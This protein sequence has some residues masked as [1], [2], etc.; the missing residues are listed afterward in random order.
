[1]QG[2]GAL[3]LRGRAAD[4]EP[5][6]GP[7]DQRQ[8]DHLQA[9][10]AG[11]G[12]RVLRRWNTPR[13]F[14]TAI[15]LYSSALLNTP[16]ARSFVIDFSTFSTRVHVHTLPTCVP[17]HR[18][19]LVVYARVG[20]PTWVKAAVAV[21]VSAAG[22]GDVSFATSIIWNRVVP[23]LALRS[24]RNVLSIQYRIVYNNRVS[25]VRITRH[26][27]SVVPFIF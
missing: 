6:A 5:A 21:H 7:D 25:D 23:C 14:F 1:M 18:Y 12:T 3:H 22:Q 24:F 11:R 27:V 16:K 9:T 17:V 20:G 10:E 2:W 26:S 4:P 13:P 15:L 8:A 19:A